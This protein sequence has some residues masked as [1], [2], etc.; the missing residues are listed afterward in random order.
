MTSYP[1]PSCTHDKGQKWKPSLTGKERKEA[2][3]KLSSEEQ[4]HIRK[5]VCG[6]DNV[7]KPQ[8]QPAAIITPDSNNTNGQ[9]QRFFQDSDNED[10][11]LVVISP[12]NRGNNTV[13]DTVPYAGV[14]DNFERRAHYRDHN[15]K[16]FQIKTRSS[17]RKNTP[18]IPKCK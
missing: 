4:Y 14:L 15:L 9:N 1:V 5:V 3:Y 16:C 10:E 12:D 7:P 13:S 8:G 2:W 17:Y 11:A 6:Y 18:L